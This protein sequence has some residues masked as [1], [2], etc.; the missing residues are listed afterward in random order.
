MSG[1]G[2]RAAVSTGSPGDNQ[3]T[4]VELKAVNRLHADAG[5]STERLDLRLLLSRKV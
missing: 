1:A 4:K 5:A 2:D 3:E